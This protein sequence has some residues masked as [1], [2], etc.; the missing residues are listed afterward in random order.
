MSPVRVLAKAMEV[1]E[2]EAITDAESFD[3][4][5]E[6]AER[7]ASALKRKPTSHWTA[8]LVAHKIWF[9]VVQDYDEVIADPQVAHNGSI[10]RLPG[11]TGAPIGLVMH[12]VAYDGEVP[13]V[14]LVPQ[15]LGA[16]TCEILGELGYAAAEVARLE[17][18]GVVRCANAAPAR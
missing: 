15:P 11:A 10:R 9:A 12:P 4:R 6:I 3:R 16:Q 13:A 2:L 14:R 18:A 7:V 17:A 8:A 1:P 5:V